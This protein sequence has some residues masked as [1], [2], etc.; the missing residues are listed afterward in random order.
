VFSGEFLL[1]FMLFLVSLSLLLSLWDS[2]T[3]DILEEENMRT[4]EGLSIDAAE[5]LV[6]TPGI[7]SNWTADNVRSL[8]LSNQSRVLEPY[9]VKEFVRYMSTNLSD[10]CSA[11]GASNYDCNMHMLGMGGYD[12]LFNLSYLNGSIVV[13][14]GTAAYAGRVPVNE[15][16][17]MTVQRTAIMGGDITRL[18]LTVWR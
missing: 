6:R 15:S 3:K 17:K 1:A 13:V 7:P 4:M 11:S 16:E 14:N 10:L 12:F 18:Y 8:G 9:K 5:S 2:S